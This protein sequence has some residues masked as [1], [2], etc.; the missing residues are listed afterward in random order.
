MSGALQMLQSLAMRKL[1]L[2]LFTVMVLTGCG[3]QEVNSSPS[4]NV[5]TASEGALKSFLGESSKPAVLKFYASWCASCKQYAPVFEQVKKS[6]S[7]SVDF[8]EI[9]VDAASSK[10]ITRELRIARIPET[11]FVSADRSTITKK[12][13]PISAADLTKLVEELKAK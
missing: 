5:P 10:A 6:M 9:D 7:D 12:L 3:P 4:A 2:A 11:A 13:G 8:Y 1:L